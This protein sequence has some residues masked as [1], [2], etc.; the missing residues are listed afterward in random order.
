MAMIDVNPPVSMSS[1]TSLTITTCVEGKPVPWRM[2]K[3]GIERVIEI[4]HMAPIP[5]H[6]VMGANASVAL[7]FNRVEKILAW[8]NAPAEINAEQIDAMDIK[9]MVSVG[10]ISLEIIQMR[11]AKKSWPTPPVIPPANG[12]VN[13]VVWREFNELKSLI[14]DPQAMTTS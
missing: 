1:R 13:Q 6:A 2:R 8:K 5:F 11:Y 7:E 14:G 4:S 9:A 12:I 3:Y 10:F